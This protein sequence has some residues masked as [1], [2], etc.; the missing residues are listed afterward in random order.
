[1]VY[2]LLNFFIDSRDHLLDGDLNCVNLRTCRP[3]E[4]KQTFQTLD[5]LREEMGGGKNGSRRSYPARVRYL[6]AKV[7]FE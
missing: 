4:R 5:Q 2:S 7:L 1:M 3:S 6:E